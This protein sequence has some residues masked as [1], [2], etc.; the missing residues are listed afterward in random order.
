MNNS[1]TFE[2]C[3]DEEINRKLVCENYYLSYT[4]SSFII[5]E[6]CI[7]GIGTHTHGH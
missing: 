3:I 1:K 4:V 7:F 2:K 6:L 5:C